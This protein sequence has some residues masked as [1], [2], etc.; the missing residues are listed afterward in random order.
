[1]TA[2]ADERADDTITEPSDD[3][4]DRASDEPC[5]ACGRALDNAEDARM[6]RRSK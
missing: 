1:M 6:A 2:T 5:P 4:G 3:P